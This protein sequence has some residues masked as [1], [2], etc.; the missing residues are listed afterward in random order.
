MIASQSF[1]S[2]RNWLVWEEKH[3]PMSCLTGKMAGWNRNLASYND[4]VQFCLNNAKDQYKLGFCFTEDSPFVGLDLDACR[5][6]VTGDV[7]DWADK[8]LR[9]MSPY[10]V[11]SN[12]SVS[13]TGIK[14]ILRCDE[15][16]KRGVRYFEEAGHGDHKPQA[17]L[18]CDSKYFALTDFNASTVKDDAQS[19]N[20]TVLS[21]LM[22]FDV[23]DTTV[24]ISQASGGT[25]TPEEL[26]DLLSKLDIMKFQTRD[27]WLKIMQASHHGT[28]GSGAGKEV[29]KAWSAGDEANYSESDI[30]RDWNSLK[31][32]PNNPVTIGTIVHHIPVEDRPRRKVVDEF[33]A[34]EVPKT[35]LLPWLLNDADRNHSKLVE[36]FVEDTKTIRFVP[37]W[38]KYIA[39]VDGRWIPDESGCLMHSMVLEFFGDLSNRIPDTA[40]EER[41][42]AVTW[43]STLGNW[44]NTNAV[45]RQMKGVR[46]MVV[47]ANDLNKNNHLLNFTNGTYDLDK[48]TFRPHDLN[49]YCTQQ[50]TTNYVEG[51]T[52]TKW[53]EAVGQIFG[54]DQQLVDYVRRL[55]GKS[56]YGGDANPTFNIFFG[57]GCN[58]KSTLVQTIGDLLGDYS[59]S[60]PSEVLDSRKD[61]HPTYLA[62]LFGRR[63][64]MFAELENGVPLAE[65]T[66]KKLTSSDEIE[67]RRMYENS[68][69][70]Q[71]THTSIICTN[72]KPKIKGSD[73]GI[74]RRLRLIPFEVDLSDRV[75]LKLPEKLEREKA[76]IANWLIAGYRDYAANGMGEC[77]AV[78]DAT[79]DY[80]EM[81]DEFGQVAKELFEHSIGSDLAPSE[82]HSHYVRNGG[83]YGRKTFI[84]EMQRKG[85]NYVRK[86]VNGKR[87]F[88]FTDI[89]IVSEF[90][91]L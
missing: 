19:V 69:S 12:I 29:F 18:F 67:A 10:T 33:K 15:T 7:A 1:R 9:L 42:K 82:A 24:E 51:Q 54:G 5:N 44:N 43:V 37:Q 6:P 35:R 50:C 20:T 60:L 16:L 17:E 79:L 75:D 80:R 63:F 68:W 31:A 53:I 56:I 78:T 3:K 23:A 73:T 28:G 89:K 90:G 52:A 13:G 36:Q 41:A 46:S 38:N 4:A 8:F 61:L 26:R 40:A 70:F 87:S 62:S 77:Q 55:L 76:G 22:D 65:G 2:G 47:N 30:E 74:W 39:Y 49:D 25:T 66:V 48:D 32:N 59:C 34:I 45:L 83:R 84:T 88:T 21:R 85:Y 27:G 91:V 64:T 72:H 81:E 14:L 11:L 71:P 86:S 58:G 57:D